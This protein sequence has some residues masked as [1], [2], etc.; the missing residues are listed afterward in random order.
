MAA[1]QAIYVNLQ[2]DS[3]YALI[4]LFVTYQYGH[5]SLS[6][7]NLTERV[8]LVLYNYLNTKGVQLQIAC[9]K[10]NFLIWQNNTKIWSEKKLIFNV[11]YL[12]KIA[13]L[14]AIFY[15]IKWA[16][17]Q[18]RNRSYSIK[19]VLSNKDTNPKLTNSKT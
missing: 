15:I 3:Q 1:Q 5:W 19:T 8:V 18:L 10:N 12:E 7:G 2:G 13:V 17:W 6:H 4:V 16:Q 11:K 14:T 9:N